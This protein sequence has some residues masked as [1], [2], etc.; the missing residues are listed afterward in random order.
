MVSLA[1]KNEREKADLIKLMNQKKMVVTF[2]SSRYAYSVY[3]TNLNS[4]VDIT[5]YLNRQT[6]DY[7]KTAR[8]F[9]KVHQGCNCSHSIYKNGGVF[10]PSLASIFCWNIHV[11]NRQ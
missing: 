9:Q 6:D 7:T 1:P 10:D 4:I 2:E 3:R 5:F 11:R 8:A